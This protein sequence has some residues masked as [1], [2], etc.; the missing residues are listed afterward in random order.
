MTK[1]C[2]SSKSEAR[3]RTKSLF[4]FDIRIS[5]FGFLSDFVI[6]ISDFF[7]SFVCD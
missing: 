6:R 7:P 4:L 5:G 2:P 1:E 3:E